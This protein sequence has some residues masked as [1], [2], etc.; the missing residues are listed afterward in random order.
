MPQ[1][2][3]DANSSMLHSSLDM[4][5]FIGLSSVLNFHHGWNEE[6]IFQFYATLYIAGNL[7]DSTT[8]EMEWMIETRRIKVSAYNFMSPFNFV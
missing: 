3:R 8:W 7:K 6:L 4:I 1:H 5:E 2:S